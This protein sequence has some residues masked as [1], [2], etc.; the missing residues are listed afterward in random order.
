MDSKIRG[1]V[2]K[3]LADAS[4]A[5]VRSWLKSKGKK[6]TATSRRKLTD[7]VA[8]LVEKTDLTFAE[9]EEGIIGIEEAGGKR[10][11]LFEIQGNVTTEKVK[12]E[13]AQMRLVV[14]TKRERA[15]PKAKPS[16]VY[17]NLVGDILRVKWTEIHKKLKIIVDAD[18]KVSSRFE[19]VAKI[20]VL[21]AD[22]ASKQA[23]IRFDRPEDYQPHRGKTKFERKTAYFA[24]YVAESQSILT[25]TLVKSELQ[26]ALKRLMSADP[27]PVRIQTDGHTNQQN[28][29][30]RISARNGD[31]RDD[32]EWRVMYEKGGKTWAHDQHAFYW[33]P[34]QSGGSLSR[35]VFS[36]VDSLSGAIRVEADCLDAE[37]DYAVGKI[38]KLQ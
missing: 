38:R 12:K 17:V 31:I 15:V 24:D 13:L 10:I 26:N 8:T 27:S 33:R 35:E 25:G 18:D 7:L 3:L 30:Y 5:S 32:E 36:H 21:V 23:Q 20:I 28:N 11:F 14:S 1:Q 16:L 29:N 37:V 9:V 2:E 34:D 4:I 6:S 19:S 22:L